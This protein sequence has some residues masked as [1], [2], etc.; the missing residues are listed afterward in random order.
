MYFY[1]NLERVI[2][3]MKHSENMFGGKNDFDEDFQFF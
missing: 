3:G 1:L 2:L